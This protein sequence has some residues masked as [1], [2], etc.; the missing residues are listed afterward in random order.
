MLLLCSFF[1]SFFVDCSTIEE[2]TSP[3]LVLTYSRQLDDPHAKWHKLVYTDALA[4]LGY[5]L[6]IVHVPL[7]RAGKYASNG[8]IDGELS[9]VFEY[10]QGLKNLVRVQENATII[11]FSAF[12]S[13][14]IRHVNE[15]KHI[16]DIAQSAIYRRGV[17]TVSAHLMQQFEPDSLITV[18]TVAQALDALSLNRG[19][20]YVDVKNSV[21]NTL[22]YDQADHEDWQHIH[23]L[24][25]VST[26]TTHVWLNK[27]HEALAHQLSKIL[28]AMKQAGD[29]ERYRQQLGIAD[30]ALKW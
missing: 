11:E 24:G 5:E 8:T 3:T 21:L 14:D 2:E 7:L 6:E 28:I 10:G 26:N 30:D 22:H 20:V 15:W 27:K 12:A 18:N 23:E 25:V 17:K 4:R 13:Q 19:L 9:R 16:P 1:L 29:F